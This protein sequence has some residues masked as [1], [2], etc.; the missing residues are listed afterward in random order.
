MVEAVGIEEVAVHPVSRIDGRISRTTGVGRP[1]KNPE[2]RALK[3][4]LGTNDPRVLA[5]DE[6]LARIHAAAEARQIEPSV[7]AT[8]I[9]LIDEIPTLASER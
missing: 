2:E 9:A 8:M 5:R 6:L 3:D 7:A 1:Q 4:D